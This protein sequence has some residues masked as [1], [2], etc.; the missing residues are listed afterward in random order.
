MSDKLKDIFDKQKQLRLAIGR[1]TDMLKD[2][3]PNEV[4]KWTIDLIQ[5]L[6]Q[7][8]SELQDCYAWKWW[9]KEGRENRFALLESQK[10]NI[11][12]EIADLL[13]FMLDICTS[14]GIDADKLYDL[15]MQKWR[16]NMD[17]QKNN[18]SVENK[19]EEDNKNIK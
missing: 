8:L 18:Y 1:G 15:Y 14:N 9:S 2:L 13:F 4:G 17:R 11:N 6:R 16:V 3:S 10:Q 12:V 5:A 7:E 19:T